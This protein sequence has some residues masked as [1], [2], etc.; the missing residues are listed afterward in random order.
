MSKSTLTVMSCL[1]LL[2]SA[3]GGGD[4]GTGPVTET[5]AGVE[6]VPAAASNGTEV[7]AG[8]L[9]EMSADPTMDGRESMNTSTF[10]ASMQ[11]NVEPVVAPN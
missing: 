8:W 2:L 1:A 5:A 11:D 6:F 9:K 3:C 7:F 10:K 4:S